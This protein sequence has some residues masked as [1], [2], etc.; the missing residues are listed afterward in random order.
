VPGV[1]WC[2]YT[3]SGTD[4]LKVLY[5]SSKNRD[6]CMS[7]LC[8]LSCWPRAHSL[9][10]AASF[11]ARHK[12]SVATR[13]RNCGLDTHGHTSHALHLTHGTGIMRSTTLMMRRRHTRHTHKAR[14]ANAYGQDVR[15]DN[16]QIGGGRLDG[17]ERN[18]EMVVSR[19]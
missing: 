18:D 12:R 11:A 8:E 13:P 10:A 16:L 2:G 14:G 3:A 6:S 9:G 7:G 15:G 19:S 1:A 4:R 17:S 5:H